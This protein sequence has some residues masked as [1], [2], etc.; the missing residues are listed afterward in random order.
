[1]RSLD[2]QLQ[3]IYVVKIKEHTWAYYTQVHNTTTAHNSL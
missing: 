1:M 3:H 2:T